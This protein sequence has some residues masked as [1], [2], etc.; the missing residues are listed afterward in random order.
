MAM[1]RFTANHEDLSTDRGYQFKFLCDKCG[2]GYMS[3]FQPS[4]TG[5]AGGLLRAA[6]DIF[7]GI[8]SN[9]GNSAYEVQRAVGGK[10][11]DNAFE[12]AVEEAKVYFKQC[13]RCGKWICPDVCWNAKA[14]LCEACAP[15]FEEDFAAH[16]AQAMNQAAQEQLHDKARQTEYAS[17]TDMSAGASAPTAT[18]A[19]PSCGAKTTGSK[20]CPEC[21]SPLQIKLTCPGCGFQPENVPKFCP[22]C[23]VKMPLR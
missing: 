15:D 5:T 11:H 18:L 23:G 3:R 17:T 2:N 7:G 21:G 8:L 10:A 6:G 9:A 14:G 1:I 20:F 4:L 16:K 22:E 12:K 13:T 19:C